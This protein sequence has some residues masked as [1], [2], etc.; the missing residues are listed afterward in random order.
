MVMKSTPRPAP[1]FAFG[2]SLVLTT[3]LPHKGWSQSTEPLLRQSDLVHQGAFRV[4]KGSDKQTFDYGGTA[5]A[6]NARNNSLY[7]VGHDWYQLSAEIS[8]PS[9]VAST[10][11]NDLATA[12]MLQ[13]FTDATEGKLGQINPTD[14]NAQKIG[15]QLVY[16]GKLYLTAYSFYDG[17]GTQATSHFARPLSLA[18]R[19][20]VEGPFKVGTQYP[21]LVDGYMTLIPSQ[22]Q[23]LLGGAVLTGNCCLA[24][25]SLQSNGPAASVFD[26]R[27][28][29]VRKPT[30]ATPVV[31][32]RYPDALGPGGETQNPYFNL[33]TRITGIVFPVG[34]RSVL[35]FGRH[36][37]G[38]YCYGPGTSDHSLAKH[39]ADGGVDVYCYDPADASKGTHAFPYTYQ[40]WAYD[41]NDLVRVKNRAKRQNQITPYAV[42]KLDLPFGNA[43]DA[44]VIGGAAY[45]S[46]TNRIY[47]SQQCADTNCGPII[48]VFEVN[49]AA[50]VAVPDPPV[51]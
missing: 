43:N 26:S 9:I 20:Q 41:A 5:L 45:D 29:G 2:V 35:F 39:P 31:G 19:D 4:P 28:L 15:G 40:V 16:D 38:P 36:G 18:T 7:L 12:T 50:G 49:R 14:H 22:W 46:Q 1:F 34:T 48:H 13:P 47:L 37:T 21:G 23:A 30:P 44:H 42:W 32:Y 6:Y 11:I 8:I 3:A 33:A 51:H 25:T 24:I 10:N 27:A 17:N